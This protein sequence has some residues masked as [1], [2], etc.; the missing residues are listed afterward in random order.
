MKKTLRRWAAAAVGIAAAFAFTSCYYDPYYGGTAVGGSYSSGYGDGY[1]YGGSS[2]NTSVFVSTGNPRWGYDPYCYSYYD[3]HRRC[4][5]DPYLHGYYPV[6][7]RPPVIVGVPHPY[8]YRRGYCPPPTY[9]K[10]VTVRNYRNRVDEYRGTNYGWARQVRQKPAEYGRVQD[11]H[12]SRQTYTRPNTATRPSRNDGGYRRPDTATRPSYQPS[13]QG[14][15]NTTRN[16]SSG[17]KPGNREQQG[18]RLPSGYNTPVTRQGGKTYSAPR[19]NRQPEAKGNNRG[20]S[21][22][23]RAVPQG[24]GRQEESRG[25][26]RKEK[27]IRGLGQG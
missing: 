21:G 2:F 22:G 26:S 19:Q 5:Y 18:G 9:V 25:S 14:R 24:G 16:N 4:Y 12:P 11:S 10:N 6:G 7:Y 20:G 23:G 8:G 1:G 27:S 13:G 15:K 3:Y 17:V